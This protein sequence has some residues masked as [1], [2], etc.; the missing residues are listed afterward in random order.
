M[1]ALAKR[2]SMLSERPEQISTGPLKWPMVLVDALEQAVMQALNRGLT[3][4]IRRCIGLGDR[5]TKTR[6]LDQVQP[7]LRLDAQQRPELIMDSHKSVHQH[8]ACGAQDAQAEW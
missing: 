4:R 6:A 3:G 5:G 1:S 8:Y 7:R 2:R